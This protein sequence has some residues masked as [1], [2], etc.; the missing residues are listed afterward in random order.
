MTGAG[1]L[2]NGEFTYE[3]Y[4]LSYESY[5]SGDRVVVLLHGILLDANVNRRLAGALA[6]HG[7]RV[8]LL[9]LLGHGRSAR[10]AHATLHGMDLYAR[11]VV[12]LLD[13]LDLADAVIGGVSLGADV[14]LQVAVAAPDRVRGLIVEMPVLENAAP[15]AAMLFVPMMMTLHY[16]QPLFRGIARMVRRVPRPGHGLIDGVLDLASA[17]PH[18]TAAVLH[19]ILLGPVAP[20]VEQ[21]TSIIAPALVI[22]HRSDALHPYSDAANLAGQLPNARLLEA[23]SVAE[24]RRSPERLTSAIVDFVDAMWAR[25][26][27]VG[28]RPASAV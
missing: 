18:A 21:R 5:G 1:S 8:A 24:L 22:G 19:G 10:P 15:V 3:G 14:A 25:P 17:D 11:Q 13:E 4:S 20:T 6:E 12:A 7:Y 26:R 2:E 23:R 9:D 16:L 28:E 27:G